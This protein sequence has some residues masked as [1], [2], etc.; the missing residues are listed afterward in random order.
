MH[1]YSFENLDVWKESIKL[2][3][4]IYNQTKFLPDDEKFGLISQMRRSS[5]SISSNIAEGTSRLTKKDKAHFMTMAY[6]STLE[7]LNQVII[8][9]ELEFIS[10][11]NY[12]NIRFEVE[13]VTNKINALRN[14]FLKS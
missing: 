12:K 11:E 13:S 7:L 14:H 8:S 9:K 10:E 3:K 6:S 5:V 1:T 4:N 2:A